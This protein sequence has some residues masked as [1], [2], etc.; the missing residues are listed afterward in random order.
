MIRKLTEN[1]RKITLNYCYK[2][3][4]INIFIIGDIENFG[5]ETDFQSVYGEFKD[6]ELISVL[7]RY[8]ENIIYYSHLEFFHT[9]YISI[10]NKYEF[11]FLSGRQSLMNLIKPHFSSFKEKPMYFA[12]AT[13]LSTEFQV[14]DND[15]IDVK[16]DDEIRKVFTLLKGIEEFDGMQKQE[17]DDFIK[18]KHRA[19]NHSVTYSIEKDGVCASTVSTVADTQKSS[20]VVAVATA[21]NYRGLGLASKLMIKLLDEYINKRNKYLC[22]F[23]DNP[24]AG[25]IYK[26]LGFKDIDKWVMLVRK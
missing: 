24:S 5:M 15:I 4:S 7:L 19:L 6:D 22:L 25:K 17:E 3:P 14:D 16:T 11:Q 13:S 21:P 18:S 8:K 20:M 2:D 12:E 1:D 10:M 23:Y 26:R 9:D